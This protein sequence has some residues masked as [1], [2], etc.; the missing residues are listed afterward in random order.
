MPGD[1]KKIIQKILRGAVAGLISWAHISPA[2][3]SKRG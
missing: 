3:V 1:G 2:V